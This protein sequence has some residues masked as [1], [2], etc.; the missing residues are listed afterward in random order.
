MKADIN[1]ENIIILLYFLY[2]HAPSSYLSLNHSI[3]PRCVH[4]Q[5]EG[6]YTG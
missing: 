1:F 6:S 3:I 5:A 2:V 4:A